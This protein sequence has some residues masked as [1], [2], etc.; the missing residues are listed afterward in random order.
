MVWVREREFECFLIPE[1]AGRS[2]DRG[3]AIGKHEG[4]GDGKDCFEAESLEPEVLEPKFVVVS[5][6]SDL[7]HLQRAGG[8]L[9]F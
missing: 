8:H 9:M 2:S 4:E 3:P 7:S 1:T 6:L 5:D